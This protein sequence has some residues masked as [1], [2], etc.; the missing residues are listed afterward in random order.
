VGWLAYVF[1]LY[2]VAG[3]TTVIAAYVGGV[4]LSG[5]PW[6]IYGLCVLMA[7]FPQILGHGSFNYAVRF[8]PAAVLGL[9][10]LLEPVGAS[11]LAIF[12]FAEVPGILAVVGMVLILA[13]VGTTFGR[14]GMVPPQT[15]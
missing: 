12:L 3:L 6:S 8:V 11:I 2:V 10:G 4:P 1:P 13:A 9:L 5:Y 7:L 14:Q 15:D